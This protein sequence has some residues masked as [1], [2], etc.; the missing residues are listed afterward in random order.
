MVETANRDIFDDKTDK[1]QVRVGWQD[2]DNGKA[3]FEIW[4]ER[5]D[6]VLI[7]VARVS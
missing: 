4:S 3:V 1:C 2:D 5:D 6:D 7:R